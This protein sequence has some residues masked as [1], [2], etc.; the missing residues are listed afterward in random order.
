MTPDLGGGGCTSLG[1][2]SSTRLWDLGRPQEVDSTDTPSVTAQ[3]KKEPS[4][5]VSV[6][7]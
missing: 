4:E 5:C 1:Q 2:A 7:V 6:R 3:G